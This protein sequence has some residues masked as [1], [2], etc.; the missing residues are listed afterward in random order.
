MLGAL[1]DRLFDES[2]HRGEPGEVAL[3]ELVGLLLGDVEPVGHPP[4][5]E[6]VNN[7]VVDHLRFRSH[8][9]VDLVRRHPKHTTGRRGVHVLALSEDLLERVLARD[10]RQEP[11]LDLRVVGA[12]QEVAGLGDEARPDLPAQLGPDRD[13]LEVGVIG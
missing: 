8:A 1:G 9:G 10:V 2:R 3:D 6:P 13:V 4:G 12:G 7:P 5:R 11:Q